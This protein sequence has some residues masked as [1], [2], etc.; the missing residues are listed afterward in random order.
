MGV[1]AHRNR[2]LLPKVS[3]STREAC[4]GLKLTEASMDGW[5]NSHLFQYAKHHA[6]KNYKAF[7]LVTRYSPAL[8]ERLLLQLHD[9]V[10]LCGGGLVSGGCIIGCS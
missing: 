5:I 1:G 7:E 6:D 8:L 3:S 10:Q 2:I 4:N 9:F